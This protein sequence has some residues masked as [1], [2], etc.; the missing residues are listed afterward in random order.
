MTNFA[1]LPAGI[2]G[3]ICMIVAGAFLTANDAVLKWLVGDY[4]VGQ[5]M[6]LRGLFAF[7]P[8]AL[9]VWRAGGIETLRVYSWRGHALRAVLVI[10]GT[11][12][13][14]TGLRYLP[15]ADAIAIAF[16]GPLF[17]T[18]LAPVILGEPVGWRRWTAVSVGF[19][20]V[21]II[22]RPTGAGAQLAGLLPLAASLTGA[23]RDILTRKLSFRETSVSVL[24]YSTTAVT[25]AGLATVP[26]GWAPVATKDYALFA[27][28][29]FF[30]GAAHFL[31][32]EAFRLAEAATAAPFKYTS[33]LWGVALGYV[34]WQD[35]PD[36]WTWT[37]A[38]VLVGSGLYILHREH[39]R[40]GKA[41]A[42]KQN[43]SADVEKRRN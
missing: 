4:S 21:L 23:L 19:I 17:I 30:I 27:L 1:A 37:G 11:F 36:R 14:V 38:A 31:M 29:G 24:F 40:G 20:G 43:T 12:L 35:V 13:F 22:V 28:G 2:K 41:L 42:A 10:T 7:V 3:I 18:A 5:I 25:L 26:F 39:T 33:L 16:A 9:L 34:F 15:L 6:F 32:I 8:L